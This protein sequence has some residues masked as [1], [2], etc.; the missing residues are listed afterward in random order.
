MKD[1]GKL[2]VGPMSEEIVEAVFCYSQKHGKPLMLISSKNQIDWDG[3][4]VNAWT[5]KAYMDY[6][7]KLKA[8]YPKAAVYVCRDHCGPGFKS[9]DMKDVYKT[10]D[11]DL[12]NNFDLIHIDFCHYKGDRA[13][14]LEESKKAIKY[15][16]AK[17]PNMLIE[18][19]TDENSGAFLEDVSAI[20]KDMKYF[21]DIAP[22]Q[23]FVV[24][25]GSIVK[26][27]NQAGDFNS[28]F[29]AKVKEVSRKYN[30]GL[31]E[32]NGDYVEKSTISK[33]KG[34][35]DAINVAPQFGVLQTMLTLQKCH[36]YGI[37]FTDFLQAAYAS[38]RWEKWLNKNT[39]DNKFLCSVLAGH[40]VFAGEA[41][42]KIYDNISAHEDFRANI[43]EEMTKNFNL[44]VTAL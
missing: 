33:R 39:A 25:T 38:R 31:K 6:I 40:Y 9:Y 16:H 27:Q 22:L 10:I 23:F 17:N 7:K 8:K 12:E 28:D 35:I 3:G 36:T 34:L 41:Y 21:T 15:I 1:I 11:S 37:D 24:Q 44:Y 2:G 13:E 29:I 43:I 18:V 4:Y 26:E 5:T 19:G 30:L 20:E 42:K 32:H 14:L